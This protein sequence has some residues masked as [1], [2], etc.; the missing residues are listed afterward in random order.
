MPSMARPKVG[1]LTFGSWHVT[2]SSDLHIIFRSSEPAGNLIAVSHLAVTFFAA[3]GEDSISL[4][5]TGPVTLA[6]TLTGIGR[7]GL[8]SGPR[9]C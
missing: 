3:L 4:Y 5:L 9:W 8:V 1:L 6:S 7:A 2:N